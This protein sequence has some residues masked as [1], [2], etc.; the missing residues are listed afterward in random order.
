MLEKFP[1]AFRASLTFAHAL[2]RALA[3][4]ALAA[5]AT[6]LSAPSLRAKMAWQPISDEERAATASTIQPDVGAEVLYRYKQ[7]DDSKVGSANTNE[8]WRIKVYNENGLKALSKIEITYDP[9]AEAIKDLAARVIKPDG[10]STELGKKAFFDRESA[11]VG[12]QRERVISFSFPG[13]APGVIVEYQFR[14]ASTTTIFLAS[15][16]TSWETCRRGA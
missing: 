4:V 7:V 11:K 1:R 15:A 13:L 6:G 3:F 14:R 5:F 16:S 2:A 12:K 8:Y 10:S 9:K